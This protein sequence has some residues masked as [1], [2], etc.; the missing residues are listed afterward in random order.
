METHDPEYYL[1]RSGG[2]RDEE[3]AH[4]DAEEESDHAEHTACE[5]LAPFIAR[6]MLPHEAAS[7][8]ATLSP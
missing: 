8:T 5:Q 4:G 2:Y 7:C 6:S 3:H 1:H